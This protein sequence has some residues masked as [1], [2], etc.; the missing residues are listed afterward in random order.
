MILYFFN[1][2]NLHEISD[3]FSEEKKK[4]K[5]KENISKCHL[6]MFLARVLSIRQNIEK[7]SR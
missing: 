2:D 7:K 1:G 4:K 6:L 3:L 5:K